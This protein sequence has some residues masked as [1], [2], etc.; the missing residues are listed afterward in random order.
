MYLEQIF[1]WAGT[2]LT[3]TFFIAPIHS[4][5]NVFKGKLNYKDTPSFLITVSYFNCFVWF[6]YGGLI[7]SLQ[8]KISNIIGCGSSLLF[9]IIYLLYEIRSYPIDAI[10]NGL[11]IVAATLVG[12][13]AFTVL[14]DDVNVIGKVCSCASIIV[15]I[16]PLQLIYRVLKDRDYRLIPIASAITSILSGSCWLMYGL[17][18]KDFYISGANSVGVIIGIVQVVIWNKLKQKYHIIGQ[19]N[20]ITTVEIEIEDNDGDYNYEEKRAEEED[21]SK[22]IAKPVEVI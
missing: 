9:I 22:I 21:V 15:F 4:F 14:F 12:Y 10:L 17:L 13:R 3:M 20:E 8:V 18:K 7:N 5:S 11:L 1:G 19:K 2:F 16:S 6:I